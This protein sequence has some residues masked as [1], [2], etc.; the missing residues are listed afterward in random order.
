[1]G[2]LCS[3]EAE[4]IFPG[5]L[6]LILISCVFSLLTLR[7]KSIWAACGLHS[8]WNFCLS[9]ILGLDLSGSEGSWA[10]INMRTSGKNLFN[11]GRYGIEASIIT[12]AV[13]AAAAVLLW[14]MYKRNNTERQA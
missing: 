11:G 13:L 12:A 7:T 3:F 1:M 6:C 5:V 4:Y 10:V 8:M 2:T 14:H 9:C